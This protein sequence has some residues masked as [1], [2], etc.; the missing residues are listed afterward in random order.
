MRKLAAFDF[1]SD[2]VHPGDFYSQHHHSDSALASQSR[3]YHHGDDHHDEEQ[4]PLQ[5]PMERVRPGAGEQQVLHPGEQQRSLIQRGELL[6]LG[7]ADELLL[8]STPAVVEQPVP[9]LLQQPPPGHQLVE[10]AINALAQ[11]LLAAAQLQQ[12]LHA[13]RLGQQQQQQQQH[14]HPEE[15]DDDDDDE[16]H[17]R[18]RLEQQLLVHQRQQQQ[19]HALWAALLG[20]GGNGDQQQQ[21]QSTSSA[22][23]AAGLRLMRFW[24]HQK[25]IQ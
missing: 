15:E 9:L 20:G 19:Q 12:H 2:E 3:D 18:Q 1:A 21:Q 13:L 6:H 24:P 4:H 16:Q 10:P 5:Q 11:Q 23:S 17:Q 8:Q 14:H 25:L 22:S 7:H